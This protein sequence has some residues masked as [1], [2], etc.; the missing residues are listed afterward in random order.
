MLKLLSATSAL[1]MVTVSG[2]STDLY[3]S[4]TPP[5]GSAETSENVEI[6]TLLHELGLNPL[7]FAEAPAIPDH[8]WC[9]S[10]VIGA[11]A[12]AA[13]PHHY[14]LRLYENG[15]GIN[16]A[17]DYECPESPDATTTLKERTRYLLTSF[18]VHH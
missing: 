16:V 5:L 18:L 13:F 12:N 10:V 8:A 1:L 7:L 17:L 3:Y 2:W 11:A 6:L 4:S 15:G 14:A 9:L